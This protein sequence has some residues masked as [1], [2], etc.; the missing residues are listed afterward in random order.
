MPDYQYKKPF[1]VYNVVPVKEVYALLKS[2]D[3]SDH[4]T[5]TAEDY[6]IAK[7]LTVYGLVAPVD[8]LC[9]KVG[10]KVVRDNVDQLKP[11]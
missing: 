3:R 4:N 11:K 6:L 5:Q 2:I 8:E 7:G 1:K 9:D 10:E